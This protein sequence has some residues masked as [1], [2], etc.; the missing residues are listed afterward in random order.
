MIYRWAG[1]ALV[2][3][4]FA[5]LLI[6][7]TAPV[8]VAQP[9]YA[10]TIGQGSG[11]WNDRRARD[12]IDRAIARRATWT[13]D[14]RL[15]DYRA[16]A[17]GHIYFL[18][19]L[20]A[21]T[22]RHLIKADQLAL[23]LYW[24]APDLT[25]QVIVGRKQEKSLPT[26]IRYHLDHLTVVM[27]NFGDR[28]YLGE[29]SEVKD[30]LHPAAPGA[31]EFYEYRLTDSLTLQMPSR[32]VRVYK[33]EVR[34]RDPRGPGLVGAV[35]LD[36][37]SADIVRMDFTFTA[38]SYLDDTLDYF[39]VR[40]ENAL[41]DERYWLP[42]RQGI[43]LR[44]EYKIL[45]FPAGGIIRAE[46]KISDYQFDVGTPSSFFRGR[47]VSSLAGSVLEDYEFEEGLYD[48][49]DSKTAA[50]SPSL[51][52]IREE[53]TRMVAQSYLQPAQGLKPAV[54]GVSSIL[55]FR[56]AEGLYLG[57]AIGR[58]YP[59][60]GSILL[61]GGYALAADRWQVEGRVKSPLVSEYDIELMGYFNRVAD[62]SAW[63]PSSGA[64]STLSALL[65][66]EDFRE[67]YWATGGQAALVR[68]LGPARARLSV[69][70]EEW[71]SA[72]LVADQNV[73][74]RYRAVRQLDTGTAAW[75]AFEIKRAPAGA[76]EAVGGARWEGRL[77][78][79]SSAV[80]GEF[81]YA[82]LA[83]GAEGFWPE[84][85]AGAGLR[86]SGVAGAAFGGSIPAQ[87]LFSAG[88]RG[89]VRGYSFHQFVGNLHTSIGVELS[90]PLWYPWL[91]VELFADA[92]W[93]GIEGNSAAR[94]VGTWNQ[95]GEPAG[96]TRGPLVGL[97]A[98]AGIVFDILWVEFARGVTQGGS[99]ELVVRV[100]REFWPWL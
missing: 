34:P 69:A 70:W 38:A 96:A 53:A 18:Y 74:R 6:S 98:G 33:V 78:A 90:R 29:G 77:E 5:T 67:P 84:L 59:Y 79:A 40:L 36:R 52:E 46:F 16:T 35:Y 94:A 75:L 83:L 37:N 26:N 82:H 4:V 23:E 17:S 81:D 62:V 20:G 91:S 92:G 13:Q 12:L 11:E 47:R 89:T 72:S 15:R 25:H 41:W 27:D 48:A 14:D 10:R 97:G 71:E 8:A 100:R 57:P 68:P 44:R 1:A 88:G 45:K 99:W 43:E 7:T 50:T 60:G 19:D 76:V 24:R 56:R 9:P 64:I 65:D 54:P 51:E 22:E 93:A 55:R 80:G 42:Y 66:G 30:A 21:S 61:S 95:V 58:D 73:D 85:V 28:I 87:R 63:L 32:E 86:L 39:N 2:L 3:P 31:L 49:L